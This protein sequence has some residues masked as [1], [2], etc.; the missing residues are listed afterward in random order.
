MMKIMRA[1]IVQKITIKAKIL[2]IHIVQIP[3]EVMIKIIIMKYMK[4]KF[5]TKINL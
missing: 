3:L 1:K 5:L 2:K 4:I